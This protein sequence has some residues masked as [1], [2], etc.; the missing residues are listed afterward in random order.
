MV[1]ALNA[2]DGWSTTAPIDTS[3]SLPIDA[4]SISA[5]G[6]KI[7]KFYMNP[8]LQVPASPADPAQAAAY[9]PTGAT[10]PII[11]VLDYGTDFTAEVAPE[12]DTSGKILRIT[13]LKPL[14]SSRGPAV[15]GGKILNI[16]YTVLLTNSLKASTGPAFT[17]DTLYSSIKSAP[18]DCSTFTDASQ[19]KACLITKANLGVA[20]AASGTSADS[21][22]LSWTFSTQSVDDSL[23]VISLTTH[24]EADADRTGV[25]RATR[26]HPDDQGCECS[27]SGQGKHLPW[28]DQAAVLLD[29]AYDD[30]WRCCQRGRAQQFLAGSRTAAR[31]VHQ[32][33]TALLVD[34]VQSDSGAD[35]RRSQYARRR[36]P[37]YGAVAGD[38]A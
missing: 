23:N 10:S 4:A 20:A 17:A 37:G 38:G 2:I 28:L 25:Q 9:L 14:E 15:T 11:D 5:S 29:G 27:T 24:A 31:P 36:R 30:D 35:R 33:R 3:F 19:K 21:V 32:Y 1:P 12:A 34:D 8:S 22:V 7:V 18:A 6:I 13:P 16:G 26:P